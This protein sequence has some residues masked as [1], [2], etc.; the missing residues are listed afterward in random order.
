MK[1]PLFLLLSCIL[2]SAC[3]KDKL[4]PIDGK[5]YSKTFY[6]GYLL[7]ETFNI[8]NGGT[9][10]LAVGSEDVIPILFQGQVVTPV[11]YGELFN[12]IADKTGGGN[13]NNYLV[14]PVIA[15]S[16][17]IVSVNLMSNADF[18]ASHPAGTPLDDLVIFHALTSYD[19]IQNG[20]KG[21]RYKTIHKK[22]NEL[23]EDDLMYI[24]VNGSY[25]LFT[26][27]PE[28]EMNHRLTMTVK[29]DDGQV[30]PGI[31]DIVFSD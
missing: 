31:R 9:G 30:C 19:F 20:Y 27:M 2:F 7:P 18:D 10:E 14:Y 11:S 13:Y 15:V 29:F 4:A 5:R 12:S 16:K 17:N 22:L 25:I 23:S 24:M 6:T 1:P 28:M 26:K 8:A 3:G 21:E